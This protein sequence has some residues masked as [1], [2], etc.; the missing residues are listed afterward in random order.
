V[1]A[2]S[3]FGV[4]GS[5]LVAEPFG[6]G[7]DC[8]RARKRAPLE[9]RQDPTA[10]VKVG[11]ACPKVPELS[12]KGNF[13][14]GRRGREQ[15]ARRRNSRDDDVR[16][17]ALDRP[18]HGTAS[19]KG[20]GIVGRERLGSNANDSC[21]RVE[22]ASRQSHYLRASSRKTSGALIS[23][24]VVC[25]RADRTAAFDD[26]PAMAGQR[27]AEMLPADA[28][29]AAEIEWALRDDEQRAIDH[30]ARLCVR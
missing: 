22:S 18:S 19:G 8:G 15:C 24:R 1:Q 29:A 26:A 21:G 23:P 7:Y 6:D 5:E 13:S 17:L 2:W 9:L 14:D 10:A 11:T 3:D 28:A 12:D 25:G 27:S 4:K 16:T 30:G 20:P